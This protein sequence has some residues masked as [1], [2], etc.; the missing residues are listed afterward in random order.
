MLSDQTIEEMSKFLVPDTRI[1][2]V[3]KLTRL[4]GKRSR[5]KFSIKTGIPKT[6]TY[7]Y[8]PK[9]KNSKRTVPDSKTTGKIITALLEEGAISSIIDDLDEVEVRLRRVTKEYSNWKKEMKKQG[10]LYDPLSDSAMRQLNRSFNRY[11]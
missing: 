4:C 11:R 5:E 2:L 10:C 3:D 7:R 6:H 8:L 1:K 9:D